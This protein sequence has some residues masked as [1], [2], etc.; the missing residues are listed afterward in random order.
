MSGDLSK[1]I[2]LAK[3]IMEF[4]RADA[5]YVIL[6]AAITDQMLESLI[7]AHLPTL[8]DDNAERLFSY[9]GP[10]GRLAD[11]MVYAH[12]LGLIGDQ[13]CEDLKILNRVRNIFAH[14]RGFLNFSSADVHKEFTK[15]RGWS[16]GDTKAFFNEV[17]SRSEKAITTKL[18]ELIFAYANLDHDIPG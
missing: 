3:R 5:G 12:A 8:S 16:G 15:F 18:D 2:D 11:K 17:I 10:L 13:T 1:P 9:R 6:A 14:P 7:L 4:A